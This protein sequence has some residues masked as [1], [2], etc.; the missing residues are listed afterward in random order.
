MEPADVPFVREERTILSEQASAAAEVLRLV[1]KV[2]C[3]QEG[4]A[5]KLIASTSDLEAIAMDD[6]ADVPALQ[7]WRR[8]VFGELA[9]DV[10]NGKRGIVLAN[11]RARIVAL[12]AE[13]MAQAK[14]GS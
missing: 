5:G 4:I 12:S 10:K 1:L 8:K 13:T 3:E 9:L 2:L 11:G 14:E 7:G 6:G